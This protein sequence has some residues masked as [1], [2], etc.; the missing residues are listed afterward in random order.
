[1][2]IH[3]KDQNERQKVSKRTEE[4]TR[5]K[6]SMSAWQKVVDPNM[7]KGTKLDTSVEDKTNLLVNS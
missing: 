1:M 2:C 5:R 6:N 3:A 7:E 4:K